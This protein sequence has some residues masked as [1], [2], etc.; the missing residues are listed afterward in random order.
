MKLCQ[1]CSWLEDATFGKNR[2]VKCSSFQIKLKEYATSCNAYMPDGAQSLKTMENQAW[3]MQQT[4]K[5]G[6]ERPVSEFVKPAK[7]NDDPN[8]A[9]ENRRT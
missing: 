9:I 1:T 6:F 4:R 7:V 5:M 8:I 2:Y 3:I